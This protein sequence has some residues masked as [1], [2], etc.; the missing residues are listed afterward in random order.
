MKLQRWTIDPNGTSVTFTA[1]SS[2]HPIRSSGNASG[3]FEAAFDDAGY[4][5]DHA[6]QGRLEVPIAGLLSGNPLVDREM[7][8]RVDTTAH[9][10]IVAE[11]ETTEETAGNT[12]RI[13]GTIAF[14]DVETL[15]QGELS[16]LPGPRLVGAG[17]FD[18]RWWGLEPPRLLML[19]VDPIVTVEIDLR[20]V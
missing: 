11:I 8:R 12:A 20:L 5:P 19:R 18:V 17:E 4:A 13:S 9:P 2:I 7:R 15:V 3:W 1:S 6:T 14:L 10:L 16:L